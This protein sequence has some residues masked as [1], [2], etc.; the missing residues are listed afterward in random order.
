MPIFSTSM[1]TLPNACVA[2]VWKMMP[3]SLQMAPISA[4]GW[5]VPISL[6]AN[7]IET[8]IVSGRIAALSC[9]RSILPDFRTGR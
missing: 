1:G 9:S 7:M 5:I 4:I 3:F 8:K 2:S 6:L